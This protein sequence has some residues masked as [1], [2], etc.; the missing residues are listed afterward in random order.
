MTTIIPAPP[1]SWSSSTVAGVAQAYGIAP[2]AL[3]SC[4]RDLL[5]VDARQVAMAL[6]ADCG[7]GSC[8]SGTDCIVMTVQFGTT[9]PC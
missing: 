3:T 4:P 5:L 7:R 6:L 9:W 8:W 1:T 2:A